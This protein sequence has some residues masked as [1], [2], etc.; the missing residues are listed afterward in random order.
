[1]EPEGSLQS[2]QDN[3]TGPYPEPDQSSPYY[4]V[5]FYLTSILILYSHLRPSHSGFTTKTL[6]ASSS[7]PCMLHALSISSSLIRS[8]YYIWRRVKI[9][10]ILITQIFFILLLLHTLLVQIFPS[11]PYS[12][13][14]L[15][16]E[17]KFH[18][19]THTH[20]R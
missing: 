6:H 8:L 15:M 2:S 5:L 19:H 18:T 7:P 14:P 17:T 13:T 20:T 10:T 4:P 11:A 12:Q 3:S 9:M 16:S 1:M